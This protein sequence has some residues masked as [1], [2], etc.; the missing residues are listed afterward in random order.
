VSSSQVPLWVTLLIA[1]LGLMGVLSAQLIAAWRE[2]RRW[3][4]EQEREDHRWKRERRRELDN[5]D[6]EGRQTAYAQVVAAIEAFDFLTYPA[7]SAIRNDRKITDEIVADVRQARDELRQCLGPINLYAPQRFNE[8]LRAAA[9]PRSRLAM[10]VYGGVNRDRD[11][12][13]KLWNAGQAAYREIRVHMRQDLGLDAE[14]LP[15][16]TA[17]KGSGRSEPDH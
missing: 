10:D 14:E 1:L 17:G 2:D 13:E 9:L 8:L 16:D 6:Y 5:R 11:H 3:R 15:D 7:M 12:V 4:R